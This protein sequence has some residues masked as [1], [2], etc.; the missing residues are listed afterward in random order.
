[1]L[2]VLLSVTGVGRDGGTLGAGLATVR[3][4]IDRHG[5]RTWA[6]GTVD[7][8]ATIYVTLNTEGT[9]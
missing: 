4:I 8:G 1:V 9:P 6:E 5:G 3:R 2:V 7:G